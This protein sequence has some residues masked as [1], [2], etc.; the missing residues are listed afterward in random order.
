[1][2]SPSIID[3][4]RRISKALQEFCEAHA[5]RDFKPKDVLPFLVELGIFNQVDSRNGRDLREVFRQ[6]DDAGK[7][8]ELLPQVSVDR[9]ATNRYWY[10][11]K[12]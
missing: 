3:K 1:M 10:I 7:L 5:G 9:K 2:L 8:D 4:A 11:N 6:V 12:A